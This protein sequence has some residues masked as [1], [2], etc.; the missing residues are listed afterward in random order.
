MTIAENCFGVCN[1]KEMELE[2]YNNSKAIIPCP[3]FRSSMPRYRL[4]MSLQAHPRLL[5]PTALFGFSMPAVIIL[6]FIR[7]FSGK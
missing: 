7:I 4:P 6:L 5:L 1:E 3:I 2:F